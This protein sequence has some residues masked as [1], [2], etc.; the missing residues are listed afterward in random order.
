MLHDLLLWLIVAAFVGG[1]AYALRRWLGSAL[2]RDGGAS[3]HPSRRR[4]R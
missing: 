4:P 3:D 2:R 1:A